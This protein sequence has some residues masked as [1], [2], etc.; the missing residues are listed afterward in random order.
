RK[1]TDGGCTRAAGDRLDVF[2]SGLAEM[3][4]H[5]DESRRHV[6][7]GTI[8][9]FETVTSGRLVSRALV[10]RLDLSVEDEHVGGLVERLRRIDDASAAKEQPA[11]H[12]ARPPR[13][14][15]PSPFAASASS[16]LPPESRYKTA[17]RTA[18]PFV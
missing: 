14:P 8:D 13:A 12:S 17:M 3:A 11:R 4:M 7:T 5:V 1:A 6:L 2:S 18:T 15:R 9:R 10:E 16:G